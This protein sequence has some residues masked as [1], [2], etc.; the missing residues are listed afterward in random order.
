VLQVP[1]SKRIF[2]CRWL[3]AFPRNCRR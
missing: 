1:I 3:I 2:L